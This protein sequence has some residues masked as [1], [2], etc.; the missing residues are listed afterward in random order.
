MVFFNLGLVVGIGGCNLL[1]FIKLYGRDIEFIFCLQLDVNFVCRFF[2]KENV[3]FGERVFIQDQEIYIFFNDVIK[4]QIYIGKEM[5][6][7]Y[8]F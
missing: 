6:I 8:M 3:S 2:K 7:I 1:N 5:I 4:I